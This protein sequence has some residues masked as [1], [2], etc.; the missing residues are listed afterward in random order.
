M[1][2][3]ALSLSLMLLFTF[4]NEFNDLEKK[5]KLGEIQSKQPIIMKNRNSPLFIIIVIF[6]SLSTRF[7]TT[8]KMHLEP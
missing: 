1:R 4:L 7:L 3:D 8:E 5:K 6:V 2:C